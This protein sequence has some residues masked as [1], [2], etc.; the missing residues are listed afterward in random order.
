MIGL[1]GAYEVLFGRNQG[2]AFRRPSSAALWCGLDCRT[3]D[4]G[5]GRQADHGVIT[6]ALWCA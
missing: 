3:V 6:I 1:P 2:P 5:A 4:D